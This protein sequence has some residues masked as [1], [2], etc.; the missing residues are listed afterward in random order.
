MVM[1]LKL[2]LYDK[3]FEQI[4]E[5]IVVAEPTGKVLEVNGEFCRMYGYAPE[6]ARGRDI[7]DLVAPDADHSAAANITRVVAQGERLDMETL[8]RRKDRTLLPVSL[9]ALPVTLETGEVV[10]FGIYRDI[11]QQKRAEEALLENRRQL[12]AAYRQLELASQVD[13]LT[14]VANRRYFDKFFTLEWR[15]QCREKS[16]I[17]LI[18][19]DIDFFKRFN[20]TYGHVAGDRCL[21]QVA[22]AL[23]VIHR[24]GDLVARYGGEE[25][26]A[27]LSG[28]RLED[29]RR[30]AERMRQRVKDLAIPHEQSEVAGQVTISVG[31]AAQV[32]VPKDDPKDLVLKADRALYLAKAAGRDQVEAAADP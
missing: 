7:D 13:S 9:L 1:D 30:I 6:E 2:K 31:V 19:V 5:A 22:Q 12:E 18:M 16:S 24:A 26:V 27:V 20:D 29:T 4:P 15:R 25:F 3:L 28:T 8:R 21:R 32:P 23:R 14:G 11:S 10:V 17:G